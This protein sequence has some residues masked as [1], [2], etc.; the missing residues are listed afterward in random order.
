MGQLEEL[1]ERLESLTFQLNSAQ[2]KMQKAYIDYEDKANKYHQILMKRLKQKRKLEDA[3]RV[4]KRILEENA[5]K[6][7]EEVNA[8]LGIEEKRIDFLEV[9]NDI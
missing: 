5:L 4:R 3:L 6:H 9:K 1:R 8:V 2:N 7:E